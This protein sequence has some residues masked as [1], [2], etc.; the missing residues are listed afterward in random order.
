M[1]LGFRNKRKGIVR[2]ELSSTTQC[3]SISLKILLELLHPVLFV[4]V[5]TH[6]TSLLQDKYSL[7]TAYYY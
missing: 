5:Q 7:H 2:S 1:S 4:L 3:L 6:D